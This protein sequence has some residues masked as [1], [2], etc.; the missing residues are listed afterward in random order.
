MSAAGLHVD[1]Q[2]KEAV[3]TAKNG[4]IHHTIQKKDIVSIHG[5]TG[6]VYVGTRKTI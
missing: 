1:A 3:I 5:M 4:D 2:K 6:N